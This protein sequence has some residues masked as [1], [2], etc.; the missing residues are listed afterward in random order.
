MTNAFTALH[1]LHAPDTLVAGYRRGSEISQGVIDAWGLEEG[2]DYVAGDLPAESDAV[3]PV[4]PS[5]EDSR[6]D[7]ETWGRANGMSEQEAAEAPIED[8]HAVEAEAPA[9]DYPR[10]ADSAK[11]ADW[12]AYVS[13]HP[14][15]TE[16]DRQW[17]AE[18]GT[19][20][21]NLMAWQPTEPVASGDPIAESA[22]E[23]ING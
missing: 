1:S 18:E 17:A 14:Q 6:A 12:V 19:T 8:L 5:E 16:R 23:A 9:D 15:A 20:K 4:R 7:W 2:V 13:G 22:S 10:P 11:K 3:A 21:S